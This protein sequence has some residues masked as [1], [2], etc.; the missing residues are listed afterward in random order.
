MIAIASSLLILSGVLGAT[1]AVYADNG[2]IS[3]KLLKAAFVVGGTGGNGTLTFQGKTYPLR[4]GGL[5]AGWQISLSAVNLQ[6]NV[7]N[8]DRPEDIEGIFSAAG[9]GLAVAAGAKTAVMVNSNGVTLEVIGMQMGVDVSLNLEGL[10]I[11][12]RR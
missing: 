3:M 4:I 7:R 6:G 5:S 10:S 8:I 12:L 11:K 9:A 2:K 1:T